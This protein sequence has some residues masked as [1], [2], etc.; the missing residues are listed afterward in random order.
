MRA[1]GFSMEAYYW[2]YALLQGAFYAALALALQRVVPRFSHRLLAFVILALF[3]ADGLLGLNWFGW[4]K[5]M[6]VIAMVVIAARPHDLR[7]AALAGAI[8]A[9]H[10]AYIAG[11][12]RDGACGLR[13]DVRA[14]ARPTRRR[15]GRSRAGRR[16]LAS[17]SPA[18]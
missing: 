17:R 2:L 5:F 3:T 9:V 10:L 1:F 6:S 15:E 13:R 8:L 14:V 12:R 11:V 18:A 4:R 16:R 7:N